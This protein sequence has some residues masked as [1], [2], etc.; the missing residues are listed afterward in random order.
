MLHLVIDGA[1]H[2]RLVIHP[3]TNLTATFGLLWSGYVGNNLGDVEFGE[4][5]VD[6]SFVFYVLV[7]TVE[8][9]YVT[10]QYRGRQR[11]G[12][13]VWSCGL[14]LGEVLPRKGFMSPP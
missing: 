10:N 7:T 13:K 14:L 6:Y 4:Y 1:I 2:R 5:Q 12:R 3:I 8:W 11:S 9:R